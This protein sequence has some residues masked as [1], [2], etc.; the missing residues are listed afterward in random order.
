MRKAANVLLVHMLLAGFLLADTGTFFYD[1]DTGEAFIEIMKDNDLFEGIEIR[2]A[3]SQLLPDNY[4]RLGDP[5]ILF[6]ASSNY[7]VD[8][9]GLGTFRPDGFYGL[10]QIL[11]ANLSAQ[12]VMDDL[13]AKW[14]GAGTPNT[15]FEFDFSRPEGIPLNDPTLTNLQDSWATAATLKYDVRTG[16]LSIE[17]DGYITGFSIKPHDESL[18][19]V[20]QIVNPGLPV[21]TSNS[22]RLQ[23][24]GLLAAGKYSFGNVM[25]AHLTPAELGAIFKEAAFF[26]EAGAGVSSLQ[27]DSSVERVAFA[28]LHVPEPAGEALAL[29]GLVI[30]AMIRRRR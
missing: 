8:S 26:A 18:F 28:V 3:S 11:P 24:A 21:F 7:L 30:C 29:V 25:P 22:S 12:E 16:E 5:T 20:D 14:G 10:G 4:L 9:A 17:N 15:L 1:A 13:T 6:T 19:D 2:S 23:A 27:L